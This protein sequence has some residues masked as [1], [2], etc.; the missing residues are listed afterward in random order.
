MIVNP[1]TV[2]CITT[3]CMLLLYQE[4]NNSY[5]ARGKD[6]G[7]RALRTAV[8]RHKV[9]CAINKSEPLL[10]DRSTICAIIQPQC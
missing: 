5:V 7:M 9:K 4:G 8:Y 2:L 1:I 10:K 3:P 6:V